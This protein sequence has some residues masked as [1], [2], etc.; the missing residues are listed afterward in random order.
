MDFS[1]FHLP[2]FDPPACWSTALV[3]GAGVVASHALGGA[4]AEPDCEEH[5]G[6]GANYMGI[7]LE[8]V[9]VGERIKHLKLEKMSILNLSAVSTSVGVLVNVPQDPLHP[10]FD[11]YCSAWS[12]TPFQVQTE[13]TRK[14]S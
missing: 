6:S 5:R 9:A 10:G 4:E 12:L 7:V 11:G 2:R 13:S 3:R 1:A 14:E 8:D